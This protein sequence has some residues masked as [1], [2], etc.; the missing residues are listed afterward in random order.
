MYTPA[1]DTTGGAKAP[2]FAKNEGIFI[3]NLN[4][5]LVLGSLYQPLILGSD[6]K[7]F[8]LEIARIPNKESIYKKIYTNYDDYNTATNGGYLGST[9]NVY[10]CGTSSIA[11][12]QGNNATHSSISIGS[13]YSDDGGKTLKAYTGADS[14]GITFG[15]IV[16][17]DAVTTTATATGYQFAQRTLGN[18]TWVNKNYCNATA[19]LTK[20]CTGTASDYGS[21]DQWR[22]NGQIVNGVSLP[23]NATTCK[24]GFGNSG[25]C[26]NYS[27]PNVNILHA[28]VGNRTWSDTSLNGAT[29]QANAGNT[30]VNALI[31]TTATV[32]PTVNMAPTP[33]AAG[34]SSFTNLGAATIDGMLIQHM[35]ITTKGL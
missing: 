31:G 2:T 16:N 19:G 35:K 1:L 10:Q 13:V 20:Y 21:V 25:T 12:Y 29:W 14:V 24:T 4:T 5:N 9:C 8:S 28:T 26:V 6:G 18:D 33:V 32:L 15:N 30:A 7:N 3:Y 34:G 22:Y 23:T 11:G 27:T 17:T